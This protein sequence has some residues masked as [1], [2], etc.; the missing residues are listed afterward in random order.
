MKRI[1]ITALIAAF[2]LIA[3]MFCMGVSASGGETEIEYY[4]REVLSKMNNSTA[5]LYA[6]DSIVQGVED[7]LDKINVY[8]GKKCPLC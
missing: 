8:D 6:Y 7:T 4:G 3:Q 5:L 2:M 1:K